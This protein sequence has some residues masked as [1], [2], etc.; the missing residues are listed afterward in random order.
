[1]MEV[2]ELLQDCKNIDDYISLIEM[3]KR[4]LTDKELHIE[5]LNMKLTANEGVINHQ[6]DTVAEWQSK[7][8]YYKDLYEHACEEANLKRYTPT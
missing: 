4:S 3:L 1:M 5:E 6:R 8:D 7:A 2:K